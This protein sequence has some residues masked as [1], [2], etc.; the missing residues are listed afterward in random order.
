MTVYCG[1]VGYP[2]PA[3]CDVNGPIPNMVSVTLN[4]SLVQWVVSNVTLENSGRYSCIVY[5]GTTV[6]E[7]KAYVTIY[8]RC[9]YGCVSYLV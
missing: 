9:I 3:R 5:D 7:K 4:G 6:D 2:P 8:G 1:A